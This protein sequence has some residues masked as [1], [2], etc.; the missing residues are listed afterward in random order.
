MKKGKAR[1]SRLE[2]KAS[3]ASWRR[4][5]RRWSRFCRT[6]VWHENFG[7]KSSFE[8][9][10]AMLPLNFFFFFFG[11]RPRLTARR[12]DFANN[13]RTTASKSAI[14]RHLVIQSRVDRKNM[15]AGQKKQTCPAAV[16]VFSQKHGWLWSAQLS[17]EEEEERRKR[18]RPGNRESA[19]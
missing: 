15:G 17:S 19:G 13:H 5:R 18:G 7:K 2:C 16:F 11:H 14:I 4:C 3:Q 8:R 1:L 6:Q 12:L 9:A 10:V